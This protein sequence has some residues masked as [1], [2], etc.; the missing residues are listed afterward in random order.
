MTHQD[1]QDP[2]EQGLALFNAGKFFECHEIWEIA[3]KQ[4]DG[5]PRAFFQGLIQAA[6]AI[7][8]TERGNRGGAKSV[9]AKARARLDP[10]PGAFMSVALDEFRVALAEFF[11]QMGAGTEIPCRPQL[12]RCE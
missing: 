6:V 4:A 3:W 5:E 12:R 9:Y 8:H 11:E 1:E 2:F 10:L 7:L